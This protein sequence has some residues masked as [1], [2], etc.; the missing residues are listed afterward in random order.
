VTRN[1]RCI[2]EPRSTID[3][4]PVK[5]GDVVWFARPG[6]VTKRSLHKTDL[7]MWWE[8]ATS[9]QIYSTEPLALAAAIERERLAAKRARR[10]ARRAETAIRR[11]VAR[12]EGLS[13]DAGGPS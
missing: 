5:V 7:G 11:F 13:R 3:G 1:A 9:K 8:S 2:V 10:E 4:V 12:Q 6:T